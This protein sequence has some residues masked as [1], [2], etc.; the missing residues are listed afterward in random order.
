MKPEYLPPPGLVAIRG[1]CPRCGG[2]TLFG[3][4]VAF[5][6]RC[7]SCGLDFSAFNVGDGPA[8]LLILVIG[9]VIT[10]LAIALELGAHPPFWVHIL[11]WLP[12]TTLAVI[13]S[14]RA[15]KA[16]LLALEYRHEAAEGRITGEP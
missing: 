13:G 11:L 6:P 14:L 15:A 16:L 9:A 12:L 2:R 7:R 1:L 5:A 8:A 3:G 10:G 4:L